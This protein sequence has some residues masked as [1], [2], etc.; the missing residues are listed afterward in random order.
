MRLSI[1]Q[2]L[3]VSLALAVCVTAPVL[4][5]QPAAPP[6]N[7]GNAPAVPQAAAPAQTWPAVNDSGPLG[8]RRIPARRSR[9]S[10][11]P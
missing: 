2:N 6:V 4:S 8:V 11:S 3:L 9:D 5:Q 1:R 7:D 10:R